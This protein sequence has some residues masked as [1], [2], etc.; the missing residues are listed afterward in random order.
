MRV[1]LLGG[2]KVEGQREHGPHVLRDRI[3]GQEILTRL[4]LPNVISR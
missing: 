4:E 3:H 1:V 2:L